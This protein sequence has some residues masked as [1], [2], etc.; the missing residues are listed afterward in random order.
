MQFAEN[1]QAKWQEGYCYIM[2]MLDPIQ[3]ENPRR[4]FKNYS[5]NNSNILLTARAWPLMNSV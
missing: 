3:P 2:A 1:L 4:E 5:G